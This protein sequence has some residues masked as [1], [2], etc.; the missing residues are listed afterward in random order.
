LTASGATNY[1]WSGG[2][3]G[4][5]STTTP[6]LITGTSYVVTG[7]TNGCTST[8]TATVTV[9][10][11]PTVS[12]NTPSPICAGNTVSLSASGATSY[13]W[14][15]GLGT[16]TSVTT[17]VLNSTIS[18]T[19]TGSTNNCT[20]TASVTV[21]VN[22]VPGTPTITQSRDTLYSS[23]IVAGASYEWYKSG[24]LV[25]TTATPYYKIAG[26]GDYTVKVISN[27]CSSVLSASFAAILTGIKN[28]TLS[29]VFAILPNPNNGQF[30]IQLTAPKGGKY[31][32]VIYN[33][34]GQSLVK[35]EVLLQ[36]NIMNTKRYSLNGIEKGMYMITLSGNDGVSTQH[37]IVQ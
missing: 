21:T 37:F 31:H 10:P 18:Y 19:V 4:S 28:N 1:T 34:V 14:S 26:S 15:G 33:A 23:V 6:A 11:N 8:A 7:T 22:T 17:P 32:L 12:A 13:S 20:G 36:A 16:G 24:V 35:E 2:L 3:T 29:V 25:A 9:N 30:D 5:S 27:S